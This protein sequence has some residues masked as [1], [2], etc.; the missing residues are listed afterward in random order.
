MFLTGI[1]HMSSVNVS[2][3]NGCHGLS[4]LHLPLSLQADAKVVCQLCPEWFQI[5]HNSLSNFILLFYITQYEI[6]NKTNN[7]FQMTTHV[8][9]KK[10]ESTE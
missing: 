3:D 7:Q 6:F 9:V 5:L 4:L 1:Q 2:W 8:C 10:K